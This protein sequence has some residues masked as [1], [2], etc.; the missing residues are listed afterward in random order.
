MVK[1]LFNLTGF[2][3]AM[4]FRSWKFN[5]SQ[6]IASSSFGFN[7]AMTFRSWKWLS[8]QLKNLKVEALQ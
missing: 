8:N 3:E 6:S 2:N 5:R 7:E 1:F 4:T